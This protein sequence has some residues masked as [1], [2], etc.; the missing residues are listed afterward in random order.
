MLILE[1]AQAIRHGLTL[2]NYRADPSAT[3]NDTR[4]IFQSGVQNT[5]NY[6]LQSPIDFEPPPLAPDDSKYPESDEEE[7]LEEQK[8]QRRR[9]QRQARHYLQDGQLSILSAQ[10][11]GPFDGGWVNPWAR[12]RKRKERNNG[13]AIDNERMQVGGDT[14]GGRQEGD[15][16]TT[17]PLRAWPNRGNA[18]RTEILETRLSSPIQT[19][20]QKSPD[21]MLST[22]TKLTPSA[23]DLHLRSQSKFLPVF[24]YLSSN[25]ED[26]GGGLKFEGANT[27]VKASE[28]IFRTPSF[29]FHTKI[30][31]LE[32]TSGNLSAR[33]NESTPARRLQKFNRK[34]REINQ[35]NNPSERDD[36]SSGSS[37][38]LQVLFNDT[39]SVEVRGQPG[40]TPPQN[41][42]RKRRRL[43]EN[44]DPSNADGECPV[45]KRPLEFNN[46][47]KVMTEIA[48]TSN[49]PDHREYSA[50]NTN[51]AMINAASLFNVPEHRK[52]PAISP[53]KSKPPPFSIIGSCALSG[54][55]RDGQERPQLQA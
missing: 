45:F 13:P 7:P 2:T 17:T 12:K 19:P 29:T 38:M 32:A 3:F 11:Y 10:L 14:A 1:V 39:H 34:R 15:F 35:A 53:P 22:L 54:S 47:N 20:A 31:E 33:D 49:V 27:I 24:E 21:G 42:P 55:P 40:A 23:A 4:A 44:T 37:T 6:T 46:A 26:R 36:V 43:E 51:D 25:R 41:S 18:I 50:N 30:Q 16:E 5:M 52:Y 48:S 9:I 8:A 28:E